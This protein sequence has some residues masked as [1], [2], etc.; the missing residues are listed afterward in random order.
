MYADNLAPAA[1]ASSTSPADA[2]SPDD[3]NTMAPTY[4]APNTVHAAVCHTAEPQRAFAIGPYQRSQ[5][6]RRSLMRR[7]PMPVTRTSL[8]GVAVVAMSNRWRASRPD[9]A[10]RSYA[11]RSTAGRQVDVSTVGAA[12]TASRASAGW[13]DIRSAIV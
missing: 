11:L 7:S 13:M 8:P 6:R 2:L 1:S 9:G 10:P 4:A 3:T 5:A 12:K